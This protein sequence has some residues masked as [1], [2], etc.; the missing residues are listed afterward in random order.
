MPNRLIPA[1]L[2]GSLGLAGNWSKLTSAR[3]E[4]H[5]HRR[6]ADAASMAG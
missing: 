3:S 1:D 5:W 2:L 4:Q 6:R